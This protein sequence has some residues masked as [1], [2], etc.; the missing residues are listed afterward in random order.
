MNYTYIKTSA[1]DENSYVITVTAGKKTYALS[2]KDNAIT[3]VEITVSGDVI[4]SQVDQELVWNFVDGVLSYEDEGVTYYLNVKKGTAINDKAKAGEPKAK[5]GKADAAILE[6]STTTAAQVRLDN[7]KLKIGSYYLH[8]GPEG[9]KLDNKGT[10]T[11]LYVQ[12]AE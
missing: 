10:D 6:L 1:L 8:R 7:K 12:T 11:V 9:L 3:T 2:H 4:T 5:P